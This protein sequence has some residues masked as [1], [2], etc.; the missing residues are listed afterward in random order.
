MQTSGTKNEVR[1]DRARR[2]FTLVELIVAVAIIALLVAILAPVVATTRKKVWQ[3]NCQSRTHQ[4]SHAVML[5]VQ[6]SDEMLPIGAMLT[7]YSEE[8]VTVW[9]EEVT[10]YTRGNSGVNPTLFRCPADIAFRPYGYMARTYAMTVTGVGCSGNHGIMGDWVTEGAY[11]YTKPRNYSELRAPSGTLLLAEFPHPNN[12]YGEAWGSG[13]HGPYFVD[14]PCGTGPFA[15]NV[16][17]TKDPAGLHLGGFTYMFA[18]GHGKWLPLAKTLGPKA[19]PEDPRG[20]WT[21]TDED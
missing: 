19:R 15:Q 7:R 14:G 8:S 4:I 6:D 18:D 1:T 20:M 17:R 13:L 12:A 21:I 9:D 11:R 5:Y 3:I 10:P 16:S 2:G